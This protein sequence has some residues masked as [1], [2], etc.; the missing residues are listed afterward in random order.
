MT[1][2]RNQ[3]VDLNVTPYYHCMAR[4]VRRTYL[5][6]VDALT[7]RDFSHRREWI[8]EQLKL[9]SSIF[10]I[11]ICAYAV[12]SNH[13]HVVLHVDIERAKSFTGDEVIERWCHLYNGTP[14]VKNH[15]AGEMLCEAEQISLEGI[16]QKYRENLANMSW[17]MRCMNETISRMAN[18][19]D[20]CSGHFWEGRFKSQALLDEKALLTCMAYVDLNPIRAGVADSLE[21]SDFTSVQERLLALANTAQFADAEKESM[22]PASLASFSAVETDTHRSILPVSLHAYLEL[23]DAA[24]RAICQDKPGY[25]SEN[26]API[27]H[28]LGINSSSFVVVIKNYHRLFKFASGSITELQRYNQH[29]GKKWSKGLRGSRL[30]YAKLA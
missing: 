29:F 25:I 18:K 22:Q 26:V 3:Q 23:V 21:G 5:C 12:M 14:L 15:R 13:Y 16:I 30:L 17:F 20:K 1:I 8:V 2:P 11:D 24:G 4:C 28:Q 6:G 19:E 7:G 27:L 10:A 9:L